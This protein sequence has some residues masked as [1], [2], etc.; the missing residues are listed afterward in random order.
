MDLYRV[1]LNVADGRVGKEKGSACK[2]SLTTQLVTVRMTAV[3]EALKTRR[4]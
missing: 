2:L 3:E 1:V 4:Q